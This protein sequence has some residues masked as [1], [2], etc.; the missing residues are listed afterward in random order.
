M[1]WRWP[2]VATKRHDAA[3][4]NSA[5]AGGVSPPTVGLGLCKMELELAEARAGVG[6]RA[7]GL[8][9]G[10]GPADTAK[11][12]RQVRVLQRNRQRARSLWDF[13]C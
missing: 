7:A 6:R 8:P 11:H 4:A 2:R 3:F 1:A 10:R 12:D 9:W 13:G 5:R